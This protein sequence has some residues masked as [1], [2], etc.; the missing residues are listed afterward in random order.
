MIA[1]PIGYIIMIA[2]LQSILSGSDVYCNNVAILVQFS[3]DEADFDA[4]I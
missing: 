3:I 2:Q 1:G 4:S